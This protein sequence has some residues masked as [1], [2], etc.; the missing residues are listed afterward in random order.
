MKPYNRNDQTKGE[1]VRQMFDRIAPK[2]DLLNHTLSAG[3][4][5]VWRRRVVRLAG[6]TKPTRI[7]DMATGTGDLAIAMARRIPTAHIVG[8]DPSEGMLSEARKK[9]EAKG[10]S[11][12][13]EFRTASAEEL[14]EFEPESFD[15]VTVAFGVRNFDQMEAG[16][17]ELHRLLRPG[18]KL[19]IL[20]F[21]NPTHPLI[22]G[23]YRWYSHAILPRIGGAISK[24]RSAYE[25]LPA[26]VD[27][28]PLPEQFC[29][30]LEKLGFSAEKPR[31]Q[32]F[33]IA[34]IYQA[35]KR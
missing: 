34:Q 17:K 2:Y 10:L 28:F 11:H 26:S 33:G 23:L 12:R 27:E 8:A 9:V 29:A 6:R 4:D 20:E 22:K 19:L 30:L 31:S 13:I 3:I 25:Y 15:V 14:S 24:E 21:S 5:K 1:E 35:E 16:L 7:L 32:S 18:G